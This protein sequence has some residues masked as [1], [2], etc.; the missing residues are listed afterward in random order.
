MDKLE[1]LIENSVMADF[2]RI[3][4]ENN[5]SFIK[6]KK[7]T[8]TTTWVTVEVKS[9]EDAYSLGRNYQLLLQMSKKV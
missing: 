6:E 1:L 8:S 9:A 2:E 7:C 4:K 3:I 5:I